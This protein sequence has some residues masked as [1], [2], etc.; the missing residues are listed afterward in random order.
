MV[1]RARARATEAGAAVEIECATA[2]AALESHRRRGAHFDGAWAS[3]ALAYD[4]PL[5]ELRAPLA[6]VLKSGAPLV[7]SLPNVIT[8]SAPWRIPAR[9]RDRYFH[10]VGG[11]RV[12][13]LATTPRATCTALAPD[14]RLVH[15]EGMSVLAPAAKFWRAW[16]LLGPVGGG[17]EW[18]DSRLASR[19]PWRSLGDH[20]IYVFRRVG[21]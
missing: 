6:S 11:R 16:R 19:R 12:R 3:F 18:L 4:A 8:L 9:A 5:R 1:E 20:T 13:I 7:I 2:S 15:Y 21:P 17:L 14:F 10:K